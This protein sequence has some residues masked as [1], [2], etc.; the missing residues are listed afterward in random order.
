MI[1]LIDIIKE[2][3]SRRQGVVMST[4]FIIPRTNCTKSM[5]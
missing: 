4:L 5:L 2:R 3:T 1:S